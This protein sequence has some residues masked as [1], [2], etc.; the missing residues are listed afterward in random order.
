MFEIIGMGAIAA[1]GLSMLV[2]WAK[3]KWK[4]KIISNPG[5]TDACVSVGMFALHKGSFDGIMVA[6]TAGLLS[7]ILLTVARWFYGYIDYEKADYVKGIQDHTDHPDIKAL[8]KAAKV[9]KKRK[10]IKA[11]KEAA[12]VAS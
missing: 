3:L 8:V 1:A 4:M 11:A 9:S 2:R 10:E 5:V 12:K 6:A 7:S